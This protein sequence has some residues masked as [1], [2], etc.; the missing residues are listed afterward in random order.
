M[1]NLRL[2]AD[3]QKRKDDAEALAL[4]KRAQVR[5]DF[6]EVFGTSAGKNVLRVLHELAGFTRSDIV[7]DKDGVIHLKSSEYNMAFRNYYLKIRSFVN[8]DILRDVELPLKDNEKG[9]AEVD[10]FS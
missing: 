2:T 10:I 6:N 5:R 4:A 3:Q 1:K 9:S 7:G 8:N